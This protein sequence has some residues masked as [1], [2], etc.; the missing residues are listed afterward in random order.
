MRLWHRGAGRCPA[1]HDVHVGD[2]CVIAAGAK[3]ELVLLRAVIDS[4]AKTVKRLTILKKDN[5]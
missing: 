5:T 2:P 4:R 1:R 3:G